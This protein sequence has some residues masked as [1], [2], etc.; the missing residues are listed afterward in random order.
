MPSGWILE[1]YGVLH[2]ALEYMHIIFNV[3]LLPDVLNQ[4][5]TEEFFPFQ[6]CSN[7]N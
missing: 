4:Y 1:Y 6:Y 5:V 2:T 3:M 7:K